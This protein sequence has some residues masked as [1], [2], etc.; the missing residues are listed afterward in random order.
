MRILRWASSGSAL[1]LALVLSLV[2]ASG[3]L[4]ASQR[5]AGGVP[6]LDPPTGL[7]STSVTLH[8]HDTSTGNTFAYYEYGVTTAYGTVVTAA[9]PVT[10]NTDDP[11]LLT[12]LTPCTTYFY[13]YSVAAAGPPGGRHSTGSSFT[14]LGCASSGSPNQ[15]DE[16]VDMTLTGTALPAS[17]RA[18]DQVTITY[19]ATNRAGVRAS[20]VTVGVALPAGVALV[21]AT[22]SQGTCAGTFSCSLGRL[23]QGE[24][25]TVRVVLTFNVAG[26]ISLNTAV[27]TTNPDP[28]VGNNYARAFVIVGAKLATRTLTLASTTRIPGPGLG[29]QDSKIRVV[30]TLASS[31]ARCAGGVR[32]SVFRSATPDGA[33]D[34]TAGTTAFT[35]SADGSFAVSLDDKPGMFWKFSVAPAEEAAY[36]CTAASASATIAP[37][38]VKRS[39]A[40]T[41]ER[42]DLVKSVSH[43]TGKVTADSVW[44]SSGVTVAV[45]G[46]GIPAG[47][48][49]KTDA[50]GAFTLDVKDTTLNPAVPEQYRLVLAEE[51]V[52]ANQCEAAAGAVAA[53]P[54]PVER[55]VAGTVLPRKPAGNPDA[56]FT[57][58]VTV[59]SASPDCVARATVTLSR[60]APGANDFAAVTSG[61]TDRSGGVVLSAP[62]DTGVFQLELEPKSVNSSACSRAAGGFRV[63]QRVMLRSILQ[64]TADRTPVDSPFVTVTGTLAGAGDTISRAADCVPSSVEVEVRKAGS[65]GGWASVGSARTTDSLGRFAAQVRID[66]AAGFEFRIAAAEFEAGRYICRAAA[67]PITVPVQQFGRDIQAVAQIQV[68]GAD[69]RDP[70]SRRVHSG[71][72]VLLQG[73]IS[74]PAPRCVANIDLA[75]DGFFGG[76]RT[77][78]TGGLEP[79]SAG[80]PTARFTVSGLVAAPDEAAVL[81]D[82]TARLFRVA[83][84]RTT[85]GGS[86]CAYDVQE[87]PQITAPSVVN[88]SGNLT[89]PGGSVALTAKLQAYGAGCRTG[90]P[91]A[92][93]RSDSPDAPNPVWIDVATANPDADGTIST[94]FSEP[95][96]LYQRDGWR[97]VAGGQRTV[98]GDC[99]PTI[100][101]F[102]MPKPTFV[103]S[104]PAN[105]IDSEL[106]IGVTHD[107]TTAAIDIVVVTNPDTEA[108]RRT[109]TYGQRLRVN[110]FS[111][112]DNIGQQFDTV[113]DKEGRARIIVNRQAHLADVDV[114]LSSKHLAEPAEG[115]LQLGCNDV[116][117][118]TAQVFGL[119]APRNPV[120]L[121][122][123]STAF[124]SQLK[125]GYRLGVKLVTDDPICT[126]SPVVLTDAAGKVIA[127]TRAT[128]AGLAEF[129]GRDVPADGTSWTITVAAAGFGKD[130][131]VR[132][133]EASMGFQWGTPLPA[134]PQPPKAVSASIKVEYLQGPKAAT[135]VRAAVAQARVTVIVEGGP[136]DLGCYLGTVVGYTQAYVSRGLL[137]D[138]VVSERH[139]NVAQANGSIPPSF[140][141]PLLQVPSLVGIHLS[142]PERY[143]ACLVPKGN[144][145]AAL[146]IADDGLLD[147]DKWEYKTFAIAKSH[148]PDFEKAV[149]CKYGP[150]V[151]ALPSPRVGYSIICRDFLSVAF[152]QVTDFVVGQVAD[153]YLGPLAGP[154]ASRLIMAAYDFGTDPDPNASFT[155][156]ISDRFG[157][158]DKF[159]LPPTPNRRV[160]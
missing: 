156:K 6:L 20:D 95:G 103:K 25:A 104:P 82:D 133:T 26:G 126:T 59:S 144:L 96:R 85:V 118:G 158:N 16:S 12:G 38:L 131:L 1:A 128:A 30:G 8:A 23:G 42:D 83:V 87:L 100:T 70:N 142:F 90:V 5:T 113:I 74:S 99:A 15:V 150:T 138:V 105:G 14:T 62:D 160:G 34:I 24:S 51:F 98:D 66:V 11:V 35:T 101:R 64:A 49:A 45:S 110:V 149:S 159:D 77:V 129:V 22:P 93:Q 107:A 7:T 134:P 50:N 79:G 155:D 53:P 36:A 81:A 148:V 136:S 143:A 146:K 119:L 125:V 21:S 114:W 4:G 89:V 29:A 40:G 123:E 139:D 111:S 117:K 65:T 102:T 33:S 63:P 137:G 157:E 108:A 122:L 115:G 54:V 32:I 28:V 116:D 52:Q 10:P 152:D 67:A 109:C 13:R 124:R 151:Q 154:F 145:G 135:G 37:R 47:T 73:S 130:D 19:T 140:V 91:V 56:G 2:L 18:G 88:T 127:R 39:V 46:S 153:E 60:R 86:D 48:K 31:E 94:R 80:L 92:I 44:C 141:V 9:G 112:A 72:Q 97:L 57:V 84:A 17:V 43:I 106:Q 68:R 58:K 55:S 120:P 3:A 27:G 78:T 147:A 61:T 121:K 71:A 76:R 69:N 132:C 75:V 41:A